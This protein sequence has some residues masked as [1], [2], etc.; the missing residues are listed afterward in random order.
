MNYLTIHRASNLVHRVIATSTT[1]T[2][3]D[4]IRFIPANGRAVDAY[5]G[6]IKKNPGLC[7]DLGEIA[8]RSAAV[9]DFIT[10]SRKGLAKPRTDNLNHRY[11]EPSPAEPVDRA[12]VIAAFINENPGADA[13]DLH[14]RFHCGAAAARAYLDRHAQ[15]L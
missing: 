4:A 2:D 12:A 15:R 7:P 6:W 10:G 9:L 11:R 14:E 13:H 1:P 5:Y 8:A 3:T